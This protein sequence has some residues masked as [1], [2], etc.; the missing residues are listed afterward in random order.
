LSSFNTTEEI[1]AQR[2]S[3]ELSE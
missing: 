2:L 3:D 1:K